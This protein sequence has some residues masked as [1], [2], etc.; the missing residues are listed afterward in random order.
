MIMPVMLHKLPLLL[1][2]ENSEGSEGG[3]HARA[4]TRTPLADPW[5]GMQWSTQSMGQGFARHRS[6]LLC[7][8]KSSTLAFCFDSVHHTQNTATCSRLRG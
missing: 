2:A 8:K 7:S 4:C 6:G 3:T 1:V 5:D